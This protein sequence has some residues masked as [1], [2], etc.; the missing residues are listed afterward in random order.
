MFVFRKLE[1]ALKIKK[2]R[3][4]YKKHTE[5]TVTLKL[6]SMIHVFAK[7]F[8]NGIYACQKTSPNN[9]DMLP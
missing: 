2:Y 9:F 7:L 6:S 8:R 5:S 3:N 1:K 4:I